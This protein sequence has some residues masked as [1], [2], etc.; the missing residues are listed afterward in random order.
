MTLG[1]WD[2]THDLVKYFS[3]SGIPFVC[4]ID[5]NGVI[6]FIG[7]PSGCKLEVRINEL[8]NEAAAGAG[9]APAAAA[10]EN[11]EGKKGN[12]GADSWAKFEKL[13]KSLP[14]I[15]GL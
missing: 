12:L 1:G 7:H 3:I 8:I 14:D 5:K 15:K 10:V 13:F 2:G 9:A 11:K 6:D 4:L